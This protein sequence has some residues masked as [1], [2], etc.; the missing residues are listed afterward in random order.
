MTFQV[1]GG[2]YKNAVKVK[3]AEEKRKR[4]EAARAGIKLPRGSKKTRGKGKGKVDP[5]EKA[6]E[7]LSAVPEED[8]DEGSKDFVI[9]P[10]AFKHFVSAAKVWYQMKTTAAGVEPL[11][12][13][14]CIRH[15][16]YMPREYNFHCGD[17]TQLHAFVPTKEFTLLIVDI[18]YGLNEADC[19]YNDTVG[20]GK[21]ELRKLILS[22]KV[23][24]TAKLWRIIV[25][26]GHLQAADVFEVLG[27]ECPAGFEAHCW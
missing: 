7:I 16:I 8:E 24:T 22:F 12:V 3:R 9:L 19:S 5:E 6:L 27:E 4:E 21:D 26:H 20:W 10:D 11:P 14:P 15:P 17:A 23:L 13:N 2:V 25:M 1:E 18:P